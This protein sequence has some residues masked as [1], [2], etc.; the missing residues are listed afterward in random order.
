[1][2][3]I[4]LGHILLV[5]AVISGAMAIANTATALRH[6]KHGRGTPQYARARLARRHAF[7]FL[8]AALLFAALCATALCT[9]VLVGAPEQ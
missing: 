3:T 9:I 8:G 7:Y 2:P 1:M 6:G 4:T 5:A